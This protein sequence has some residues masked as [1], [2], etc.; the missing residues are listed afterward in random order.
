MKKSDELRINEI[1]EYINR[2]PAQFLFKG[3]QIFMNIHARLKRLADLAKS[4]IDD[5]V[6]RR[7]EIINVY[8]LWKTSPTVK[9][10]NFYHNNELRKADI[11]LVNC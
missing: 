7:A 1:R 3:Y 2:T 6:K 8:Q 4:S 10:Q 9:A 11:R 5:R